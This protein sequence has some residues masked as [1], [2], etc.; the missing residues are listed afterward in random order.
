MMSHGIRSGVN[1][2]RRNEQSSSSATRRDEQ[3]LREPGHALEQHVVLGQHR[4]Q[5]LLDHLFQADDP[6]RDLLSQ[7]GG[8][9]MDVLPRGRV[10]TAGAGAEWG[11]RHDRGAYPPAGIRRGSILVRVY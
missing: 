10:P 5:H 6:P 3:R 9:A 4:D 1:W 11:E 7:G 8:R 2:M